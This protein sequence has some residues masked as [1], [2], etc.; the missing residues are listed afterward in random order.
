MKNSSYIYFILILFLPSCSPWKESSTIAV[1]QDTTSPLVN[2]VES[3]QIIRTL[4]VQKKIGDLLENREPEQLE[5]LLNN[6]SP[7]QMAFEA[8]VL[9]STTPLVAVYYFQETKESNKHSKDLESLANQYDGQIK[10]VVVNVQQLY[11]LAQDAQIEQLPTLLLV[12]DREIIDRIE[13]ALSK[14]QLDEKLK[15]YI[16]AVN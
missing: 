4:I 6:T 14:D 16:N 9:S 8:E 15:A 5:L 13:S 3:T 7:A 1:E 12:K 11:S 2:L 10:F